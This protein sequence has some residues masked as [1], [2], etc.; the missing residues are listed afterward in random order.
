[1]QSGLLR[2][3]SKIDRS[4]SI[5][6]ETKQIPNRSNFP[7]RRTE[8]ALSPWRCRRYG[9]KA[10]ARSHIE[11]GA[12]TD[13]RAAHGL[14]SKTGIPA[15]RPARG[16]KESTIDHAV[17]TRRATVGTGAVQARLKNCLESERL[18]PAS[19]DSQM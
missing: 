2:W 8:N 19:G 3:L 10:A 5:V 12:C 11:R 1:A 16:N 7:P 18:I 15:R 17:N 9:G 6:A 4:T 13:P 14:C